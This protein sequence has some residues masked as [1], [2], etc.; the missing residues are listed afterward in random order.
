MSGTGELV[1]RPGPAC[2]GRDQVARVV[3]SLA[4]PR[5]ARLRALVAAHFDFIWR[6]LRRMGLDRTDAD[7]ATQQVFMI[8]TTKLHQIADGNERT[9][10]YGVA[11][12]VVANARRKRAR[13][14]EEA[15]EHA[16]ELRDHR[17]LPD[18]ILEVEQARVLF[19]DIAERLPAEMR[20][21]LILIEL[22][23]LSL[24]AA[25]ALEGIPQGTVASRLRRAR[26]LFQELLAARKL[27]GSGW[28]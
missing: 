4:V 12:R 6:V 10:L 18:Q 27:P 5:E 3:T 28:A 19:D 2:G 1:W 9:Y 16:P 11:L 13:R 15:F 24:S 8:A 26:M 14:R 7:D 23:D 17:P 25:A 20:R 22:E 21:V